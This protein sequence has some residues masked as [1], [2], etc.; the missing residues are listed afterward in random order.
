MTDWGN[1]AEVLSK[2][3]TAYGEANVNRTTGFQNLVYC[4][5]RSAFWNTKSYQD[6]LRIAISYLYNVVHDLLDPNGGMGQSYC[7][8]A[9]LDYHTIAE[10]EDPEPLTWDMIVLA[11]REAPLLG[12]ASTIVTIDAMRKQIWDKPISFKDIAFPEGF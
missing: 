7:L 11:W 1:R 2:L 8:L 10:A 12:R 5:D 3:A 4:I 6:N 9:F